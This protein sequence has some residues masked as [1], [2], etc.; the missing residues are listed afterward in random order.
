VSTA[1]FTTTIGARST[2]AGRAI[3]RLNLRQVRPGTLVVATVCAGMSALVAVQYRTTFEGAL[4]QSALRALVENPAIRIIF[5]PPVALDNAGGFTVWRTG[6]PLLIL[7]SVWIL[8]AA[9]RITRGEEDAGRYELL[10]AGPLRKVSLVLRSLVA[11]T[12]AALMISVAVGIA[13][14]LVGTD[15]TGAIVYAAAVFG[16]ILT[17]ATGA[18]FAA[19]IMPTRPSA[20]GL[21]V[22]LLGVA[23]L[24][25]MLADAAPRFA[26]SAWTTPFGLTAR[27]GP[28]AAN[29]VGPLLVLAAF[30]I[31]LSLATFIAARY[32]DAGSGV[33]NM[34][35]RRAPRT[36]LLRSIGGFAVRRSI[37]PTLGW[38][39][40]IAVYFF[41]LGTL[42][43]SI[44]EFFNT[45]PRFAELAAAAGFAGLASAN[46]FAAALFGLLAI[47]TGLYAATR[48]GRLVAD[49]RA[50]RWTAVFATDISRIRL[51]GDEIAVTTAGLALLHG[52][53]GLAIW[54]GA[55]ITAAPLALDAALAGALNSAPIAWLAVGAASL[56][57]GWLPSAV[58]AAGALPVAA[59]FVLNVVTKGTSAPWWIV[60]L[61]PFAHLAAVPDAPPDWTATAVFLLIGTGMVAV[62]LAGYAHRDL[63]T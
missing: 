27:A 8:L 56:A 58:A 46:G 40:A 53:A 59:G 6:T 35:T 48:L 9:T 57:V 63:T 13:L 34:A 24:V 17:F 22:A 25:R 31:A 15:I 1:A 61:S 60:G 49:E 37:A 16:V 20:I 33:V 47:P 2:A 26:W 45:N 38:A 55:A 3:A 14:V 23:L 50:R 36:G 10:L 51:V 21:T 42:I 28:F 44:L 54:A 4:D 29:R 18:V 43:A 39:I 5:G 62:G 41:I 12:I 52:V 30:P 19:Q 11:L 7:A 32:R